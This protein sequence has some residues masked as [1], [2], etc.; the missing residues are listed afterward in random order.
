MKSL[1]IDGRWFGTIRSPYMIYSETNSLDLSG[2]T[3]TFVTHLTIRC[4]YVDE[5]MLEQ[6]DTLLSGVTALH[7]EDVESDT[8]RTFVDFVRS[9][10]TLRSLF[11]LSCVWTEGRTPYCA[12]KLPLPLLDELHVNSDMITGILD[13]I[14][15]HINPTSIHLRNSFS[16]EWETFLQNVGFRRLRCLT[17]TFGRMRH[18]RLR[19]S[20]TLPVLEWKNLRSLTL[21]SLYPGA[22]RRVGYLLWFTLYAFR[23]ASLQTIRLEIDEEHPGE[24][25]VSPKGGRP[26]A[27]LFEEDIHALLAQPALAQLASFHL[28]ISFARKA[29]RENRRNIHANARALLA[30]LE[31]RGILTTT[32]HYA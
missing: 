2:L 25:N 26:V 6:L 4:S 29:G 16:C 15:A 28:R 20:N 23:G 1:V 32:I 21:R 24:L 18:E 7:L 3:L 13:G 5:L 11:L 9:C 30:S 27:F 17:V 31:E 22:I 10:T 12:R 8:Q 19:S 14:S